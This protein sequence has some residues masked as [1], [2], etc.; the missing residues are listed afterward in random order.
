MNSWSL[1][2]EAGHKEPQSWISDDGGTSWRNEKMGYLNV[3][4][5][6]YVVRAEMTLMTDGRMTNAGVRCEAQ[7][8]SEEGFRI[9]YIEIE[10]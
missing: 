1:A 6:E 10:P 5:G 8:R 4:R 3:L 9:E 7:F 2:I